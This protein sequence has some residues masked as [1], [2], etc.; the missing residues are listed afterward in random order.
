MR[1]DDALISGGRTKYIQAFDVLSNRP[2]KCCIK[3]F[4]GEWLA[5][6]ILS[7]NEAGN[8]KTASCH[9][10][11][12]HGLNLTKNLLLDH[13]LKTMCV[14]LENDGSKDNIVQF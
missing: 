1:I 7:Y 14:N 5:S 6:R 3:E 13:C 8:M 12:T 11:V 2:C 9:L 4:Y 10:I